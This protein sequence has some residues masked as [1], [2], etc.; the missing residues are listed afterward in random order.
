MQ[1]HDMSASAT[2]SPLAAPPQVDL[3]CRLGAWHL[4]LARNAQDLHAVALLRGQR[5]RATP[6][7]TALDWDQFDPLCQHLMVTQSGALQATA[8]LRLLG[9]RAAFRACY[10]GQFYDLDSLGH[11][12]RRGLELGRLCLAPDAGAGGADVL[13]VL[14]SGVARL[15]LEGRAQVL[16]GCASFP[17]AD[18][19]RHAPALAWLG[20]HHTGSLA[21]RPAPR[22][23][24]HVRLADLGPAP[25]QGARGLPALLR[26][27]L[28]LGGWVSDHAVIDRD[29]DTLH[30]M[31]AVPVL[32]IPRARL[33][34]L[35]VMARLAHDLPSAPGGPIS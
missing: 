8:R 19:A 20:A 7:D 30:V 17:G 9:G 13:R 1:G 5:F 21:L 18:L 25:A 2:A 23:C 27:Y 16:F 15:A 6:T 24:A 34:R 11:S 26:M 28:G 32:H 31:V 3:D 29:L 22:A 14:L 35:E 33:Q 12:Y 4:H 10:T